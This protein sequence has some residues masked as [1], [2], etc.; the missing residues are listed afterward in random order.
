MKLGSLIIT[1]SVFGS[2]TVS[3]FV[4][5]A[6]VQHTTASRVSL[7]SSMPGVQG[8]II[9]LNDEFAQRD[10]YG[11]EQ[12]ALGYGVQKAAGVELA[13]SDGQDW[14]LVAQQNMPAGSPV[15][16]V[17]AQ[18]IMSSNNIAQEFGNS[19]S[20]AEQ[21]LVQ[22][23]RGTQ[24]RLPLFRLMVKVLAE[25]EKGQ[26]SPYFPWL[27][28]LPRIFYN[29]VAM[30]DA[31]FDCLPPYAA[32]LSMNERN[33]YSR[34]VNAIRRGYMPLRPDTINDD[35]VVKWAYNVA[36]TRFHEV[37]EPTRQKYLVPMAD[38]F[39]HNTNPNVE[40]NFD[41]QGNCVVNT[42]N[43][44]QA[45]SPLTI[46]LGDPTNPTPIFA[47]YGFLYND[48]K[49]IFC[50]AIHLEDE[51]E[52][53]GFNFRDLLFQTETGE[54]APHVWDLFLYK[55]LKDNDMNAANQFMVAV[56][57]NDGA[58]QQQFQNNY[59]PYAVQA[60]KEHVGGILND[61][62]QLTMKAQSYDLNTH[63][64]VPVIVAHNN[65]VRDT[66]TMTLALLQKY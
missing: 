37:W 56:K 35:K 46:S 33:T 21:F 32:M 52:E 17:P 24:Q 53:L 18:L 13:S 19:I 62:N 41:Q 11:M 59:F 54:I 39:N 50:K 20:Q 57:T 31:C 2:A 47:K 8:G 61:V 66:F 23:D 1:A 9:N 58:A 6:G 40:L 38:M 30:T 22:T 16:F 26:Q 27:N 36:L 65:L 63:P 64:R 49:T 10:V 12:W 15:L 51:I 48:C 25:Y 44:V 4:P 34:F 28:S 55:V 45:G 14:Q 7:Q 3:A 5:P 60:L 29:G 42:M 43:N